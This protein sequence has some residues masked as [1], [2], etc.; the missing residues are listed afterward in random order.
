M[1]NGRD[2]ASFDRKGAIMSLPSDQ[3]SKITMRPRL[4]VKEARRLVVIRW[5]FIKRSR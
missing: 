5:I 1:I 2:H 4:P 3:R